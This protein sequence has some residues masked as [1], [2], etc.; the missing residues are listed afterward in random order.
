MDA[1]P[2]LEFSPLCGPLS[3]GG[4]TLDI[5]VYRVEGEDLWLLEIEGQHGNSTVWDDRFGTD[6]EAL[7]E[8]KKAILEDT[9]GAF[10]GP[11]DGKGDGEWR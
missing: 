7:T 6:S 11:E 5:Q 9:A 10:V 4:Q 1:D 8:A 2:E 3:S